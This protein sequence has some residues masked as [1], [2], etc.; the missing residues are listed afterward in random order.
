MVNPNF[1]IR[2]LLERALGLLGLLTVMFL[3]R[4]SETIFF[5]SNKLTA[6]KVKRGCKEVASSLMLFN[7]LKIIQLFRSKK[8]VRT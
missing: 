3:E 4:V 2:K 7:L 6:Y 1:A 5:Q 8:H